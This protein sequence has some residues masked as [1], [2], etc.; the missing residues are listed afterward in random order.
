MNRNRAAGIA[1]NP[2]SPGNTI[3]TR[4]RG[5][6]VGR[7]PKT[8]KRFSGQLLPG[9][10]APRFV[11]SAPRTRCPGHRSTQRTLQH[12]RDA[13]IERRGSTS[14]DCGHLPTRKPGL[15][16]PDESRTQ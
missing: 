13:R 3:L 14:Y 10:P 12:F 9:F 4:L 11:G 5:R 6:S 8:V 15:R 1:H 16:D 2:N 7:F